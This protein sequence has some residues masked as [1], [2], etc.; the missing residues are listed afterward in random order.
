MQHSKVILWVF[1]AMF[2]IDES[3]IIR[4]YNCESTFLQRSEC[5]QDLDPGK[6]YSVNIERGPK[7]TYFTYFIEAC[8]NCLCPAR[9][10]CLKGDKLSDCK[11]C[12]TSRSAIGDGYKDCVYG[13]DESNLLIDGSVLA[14]FTWKQYKNMIFNGLWRCRT[15]ASLAPQIC[16]NNENPEEKAF[17][18]RYEQELA[19]DNCE[20]CCHTNEHIPHWPRK[21]ESYWYCSEIE[22]CVREGEVCYNEDNSFPICQKGWQYCK[23]QCRQ[24]YYPCSITTS[25]TPNVCPKGQHYC[26]GRCKPGPCSLKDPSHFTSTTPR[27]WSCPSGWRYCLDRCKPEYLGCGYMKFPSSTQP[28]TQTSTTTKTES[29]TTEANRSWSHSEITMKHY[30]ST[31]TEGNKVICTNKN[32]TLEVNRTE[33]RESITSILLG[34]LILI[35]ICAVLIFLYVYCHSRNQNRNSNPNVETENPTSEQDEENS[36]YELYAFDPDGPRRD[37]STANEE[38]LAKSTTTREPYYYYNSDEP[39]RSSTEVL[40]ST[41]SYVYE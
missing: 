10:D 18:L 7:D 15:N 25:P 14:G 32:C 1:L 17:L 29:T 2:H 23:G 41:S 3:K 35:I 39:R 6:C 31:S 12:V 36:Y 22:N 37:D 38:M 40:D 16:S 19:H 34:L 13:M 11:Y 30:P 33:P 27:K 20:S 5:N 4:Q 24:H 26:L 8:Q 28:V 9:E 21:L